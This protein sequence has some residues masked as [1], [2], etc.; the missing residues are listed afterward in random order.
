M[1]Y[2]PARPT[3]NYVP[4]AVTNPIEGEEA[5]PATPS[6]EEAKIMCRASKWVIFLATFQLVWSVFALLSGGILYFAITLIFSSMGIHGVRRQSPKLLTAHFVFSIIVYF[7][8][9]FGLILLV[10][11]G[12]NVPFLAFVA[13]FLLVLIQAVGIRHSRILI[14]MTRKYN[15]SGALPTQRCCKGNSCTS[16]VQTQIP[17]VEQAQIPMVQF[18][19]QT[20]SAP[21]A[22]PPA[23]PQQFFIVPP[24][25][26]GSAPGFYPMPMAPV[27]RYPMAPQAIPI[28]PSY[29]QPQE[30]NSNMYPG[31]TKQ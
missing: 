12:E 26:Q 22:Q 15:P 29:M 24:Q 20:P 7:F 1:S 5:A 13:S 11:Y 21:F 28:M 4:L 8:S 19:P 17:E 9:I 14:Q 3:V 27:V 23:Y 16:T 6:V 31:E 30:F 2:V 10:L 25:T 18:T